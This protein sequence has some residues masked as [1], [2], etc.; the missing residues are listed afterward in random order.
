M[1]RLKESMGQFEREATEHRRGL[2]NPNM[3]ES[4]KFTRSPKFATSGRRGFDGLFGA[5]DE[6]GCGACGE[7]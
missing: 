4:P 5:Q 6:C 7:A 3:A 1:S 2:G